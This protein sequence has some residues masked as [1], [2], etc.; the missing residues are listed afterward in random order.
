MHPII[1]ACYLHGEFVKIHPFVDGNGRTSRLL[2][3]FELVKNGYHS[4]VMKNESRTEYYDTLDK[5]HT[6]YDY[7]IFI[8]IIK[9]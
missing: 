1:R 5:A 6:T 7:S 3:N 2:L 4:A 9:N 8:Q